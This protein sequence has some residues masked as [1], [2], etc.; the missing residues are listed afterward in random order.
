MKKL[1]LFIFLLSTNAFALGPIFRHQDVYN[2]QEFQN[3]YQDIR[4]VQ[5]ASKMRGTNTNDNAS[6]GYI[7]EEVESFVSGAPGVNAAAT[8]TFGNITSIPLDPGDWNVSGQVVFSLMGAT[9]TG[10][11]N[12]GI[13][14]YSGNTTTDKNDGDNHLPILP[15]TSSAQNSI[16]IADYRLSLST[17][18]TVYL[19]ARWN[20]SA[21][22]PVMYGKIRARRAR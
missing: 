20:Y 1:L 6:P 22:T 7:G 5:Y 21:G 10:D 2:E 18:T 13:S 9:T 17:K 8:G 14:I 19:K 4:G 16:S 3:I 11:C 12:A 15:P